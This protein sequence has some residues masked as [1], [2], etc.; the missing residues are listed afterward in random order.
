MCHA[1]FY[2]FLRSNLFR[3]HHTAHISSLAQFQMGTNVCVRIVQSRASEVDGK[4]CT[5]WRLIKV[6]GTFADRPYCEQLCT[7]SLNTVPRRSVDLM[8]G[9]QNRPR[10]VAALT[11]LPS[12]VICCAASF[13]KLLDCA[14]VGTFCTCVR[15]HTRSSLFSEKGL[16]RV[17]IVCHQWGSGLCHLR[18]RS[19]PV[20]RTAS[21]SEY[22]P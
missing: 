12:R 6:S 15:I 1:P 4:R 13:N 11:Q 8:D 3:T 19:V 18:Q 17:G 20:L 22:Y 21:A 2:Q 10:P 14:S 16:L 5:M 7:V 9:I